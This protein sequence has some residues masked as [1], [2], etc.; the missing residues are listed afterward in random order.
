MT[1]DFDD[2]AE[3]HNSMCLVQLVFYVAKNKFVCTPP[4]ICCFY[5]Y[6]KDLGEEGG[7]KSCIVGKIVIIFG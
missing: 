6:M 4:L 5:N 7:T 1:S 3:S 2:R